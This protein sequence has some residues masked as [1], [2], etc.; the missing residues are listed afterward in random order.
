VWKPSALL[1]TIGVLVTA[2][3]TGAAAAAI[4]HVPLLSGLLLGS[5]VASTDAAAVF[6]VLRSQGV[7]LRER[8]AATLE[9]ESGSNDPLAI[10]LTVGCLEVITGRTPIGPALLLL[11]VQQMGIG[12]I[13]GL[14]I[15]WI[16]ARLV[17]RVDL[18]SSGLYP[19]LA[20]ACGLLAFGAAAVLGGSGFLAIYFAGIVL[21]NS[22]L[23]FGRGTALFMDGLAWIS[24][25]T[26]FVALGLLSTP[27]ELVAVAAPALL[28]AAILIV[29]ARPAA[30]VP[31]LL[32]FGFSARE[33]LLISWVGLKGAV[34]IILATFPLVFDVPYGR[35]IFNVVFFVVLVSATLQGW[36]LP[37]LATRLGLQEPMTPPPAASLEIRSLRDVNAEIVDVAVG[38][39]SPLVGR[40]VEALQLPDTAILAMV[41]RGRQLIAPRGATTLR[42]GDHLFVITP[43]ER[44]EE[45]E[46]ILD[47]AG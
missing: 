36:T 25:I 14:G 2:A 12:A 16:G 18:A 21:G 13:A 29:V 34:P 7:H 43:R 45:V 41:T 17:N 46:S 31:L 9:I 24:Q 42:E 6:S 23:V 39:G 35:L 8:V 4:L 37:F 47:S 32:P 28:V 40:T 33:H 15:G 1:A 30:V 3:I 5:I 38:A 26:M 19:V 11:F 10:F 20:G 27:S 44:R 22:R